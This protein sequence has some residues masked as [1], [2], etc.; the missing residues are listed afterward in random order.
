MFN[1]REAATVQSVSNCCCSS[2]YTRPPLSRV[3][4]E[5]SNKI[6]HEVGGQQPCQFKAWCQK[7]IQSRNRQV[8]LTTV[9]NVLD[10]V[11]ALDCWNR[12]ATWEEPALLNN[13]VKLLPHLI[14]IIHVDLSLW[15]IRVIIIRKWPTAFRRFGW[16]GKRNHRDE[17]LSCSGCAGLLVPQKSQHGTLRAAAGPRAAALGAKPG[18][19]MVRW[20]VR[21]VTARVWLDPPPHKENIWRPLWTNTVAEWYTLPLARS[22]VDS[23]Y[24]CVQKKYST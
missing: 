7:W 6:K 1:S 24:R 22:V 14:Y 10:E 18:H 21:Q 17:G 16:S 2:T 9:S 23:L 20:G 3:D 11:Q 8:A 5:E 12:F 4:V 19:L 13:Y 15:I